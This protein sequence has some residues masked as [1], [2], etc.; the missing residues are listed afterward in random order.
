MP[1][2]IKNVTLYDVKE[3]AQVLNSHENTIRNRINEG[4]IKAIKFKSRESYWIELEELERLVL[5]ENMPVSMIEYRLGSRSPK[6]GK[7]LTNKTET[8]NG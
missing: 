1:K 2:K 6:N 5:S 7:P 8:A 3:V 4:E